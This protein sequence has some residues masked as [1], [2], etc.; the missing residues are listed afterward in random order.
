MQRLY[1]SINQGRR[2]E[3]YSADAHGLHLT[4][5]SANASGGRSTDTATAVPPRRRDPK[6]GL[7]QV[8]AIRN[9]THN[10]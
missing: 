8:S 7:P 10:S 3:N 5:R 1:R 6:T 2:L 9:A 4:A